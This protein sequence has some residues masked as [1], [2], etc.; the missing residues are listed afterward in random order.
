MAKYTKKKKQQLNRVRQFIRRAEKRGYQFTQELKQ[1]L[2]SFSTQKL[3]ALSPTKLY[4]QATYELKGVKG[5]TIDTLSGTEFRKIERIISAQKGVRTRK[6]RAL[7]ITTE[8]Y[9]DKYEWQYNSS[10]TSYED[11][12]PQEEYLPSFTRIVLDNIEALIHEYEGS[13]TELWRENAYK[14]EDELNAQC[15]KYGEEVIAHCC[16]QAPQESIAQ[17]EKV[18]HSSTTQKLVENLTVFVMI[19]TGEIPTIDDAK[20]FGETQDNND[21][22]WMQNGLA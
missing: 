17:A 15:V 13:S 18:I 11:E 9:Y 19:I 3:K 10:F 12:E 16:E 8:E 21:V 1:N 5:E 2:P 7:G 6:A 22:N 14:L 20:K 4:Q